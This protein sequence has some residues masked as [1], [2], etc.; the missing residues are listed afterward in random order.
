[1]PSYDAGS[2]TPS[3]PVAR[4]TLR[5][6]DQATAIANVPMILDTGADVPLVPRVAAEK[7]ALPGQPA[8][9]FELVGFDGHSSTAPAFDL[10]ITFAGRVFRGRFLL[11]DEEWGI[12]GRNILNSLPIQFY[13]P[14]LT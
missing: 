11:I 12:L 8:G 10:E 14:R 2:F 4:V 7:L 13:G 3:A 6:S 5:S 9:R 1:M